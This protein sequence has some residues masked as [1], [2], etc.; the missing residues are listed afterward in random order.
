[1]DE[2]F[3]LAKE[4][5]KGGKRIKSLK[6][7]LAINIR[8]HLKVLLHCKEKLSQEMTVITASQETS[9]LI[10]SERWCVWP[11]GLGA[12]DVNGAV[13]YSTVRSGAACYVSTQERPSFS[14]ST[15][16]DLSEAQT[17]PFPLCK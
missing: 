6:K 8:L 15:H 17:A 5:Q 7:A 4:A 11:Q 12:N 16:T 13:Q 10:E 9:T 2:L 3:F 14:A 1:M